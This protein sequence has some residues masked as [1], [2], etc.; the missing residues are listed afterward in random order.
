M[1]Q[2]MQQCPPAMLAIRVVVIVPM[3]SRPSF[4]SLTIEN[5]YFLIFSCDGKWQ[6]IVHTNASMR[7]TSSSGK[8]FSWLLAYITLIG[9]TI[10]K[11]TIDES[12]KNN[13]RTAAASQGSG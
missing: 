9:T 4:A 5:Q 6:P 1:I 8:H 13:S 11:G 10:S 12:L 3:V 7:N 2:P